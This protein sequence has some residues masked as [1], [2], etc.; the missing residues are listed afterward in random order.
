MPFLSTSK[1]SYQSRRKL[2]NWGVALLIQSFPST[3]L[4]CFIYKGFVSSSWNMLMF[5]RKTYREQA[6][7]VWQIMQPIYNKALPEQCYCRME[8][9]L[10]D[11]QLGSHCETSSL[12]Y[13]LPTRCALHKLIR[14][15]VATLDV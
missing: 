1:N 3:G 9:H 15:S 13:P 4:F 12:R 8:F 5:L 7:Q 2:K 11:T 6:E 10:W 14:H